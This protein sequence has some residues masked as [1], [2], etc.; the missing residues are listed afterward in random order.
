MVEARVEEMRHE[1]VELERHEEAVEWGE[2]EASLAK[3]LADAAK[4]K[5]VLPRLIRAGRVRALELER[6]AEERR[7]ADLEAEAA[8]A[9][10]LMV[11]ATAR[12]IQAGEEHGRALYSWTETLRRVDKRR[13]RIKLINREL[14][15]L[16]G[17]GAP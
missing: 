7:A 15:E 16:R 12:K 13:R 8:E 4:R 9:H 3:R 14:G 17:K 11:A 10:S 1:L 2:P 5:L 6:A